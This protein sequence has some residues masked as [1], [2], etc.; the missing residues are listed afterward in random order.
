MDAKNNHPR[1]LWILSLAEFGER[2]G[3]YTMLGIFTLYLLS[4]SIG[5]SYDQANTWYGNFIA[6]VYFTPFIGA[7]LA[8]NLLKY[9]KSITIGGILMGLGYFSLSVA[10]NYF[11]VAGLV[12]IILGN[13]FFKPNISVL[14][15]RLYKDFGYSDD[16]KQKGFNIFYF[17]INVGAFLSN[18]V[19]AYMR[20]HYSWGWAYI[21]A[22]IGMFAAIIWFNASQMAF[23]KELKVVDY[24]DEKKKINL[25]DIFLKFLLPI[26]VFGATGFILPDIFDLDTSKSIFKPSNLAFIT[27][28]IFVGY[29]F[30]KL[31]KNAD[32]LEKEPIKGLIII[33]L[34]ISIFWALFHTSGAVMTN[35][36]A[37]KI[38][39]R[40]VEGTTENVFS[41]FGLT[42]DVTR[43]N[44]PDYFEI[45]DAYTETHSTVTVVNSELFQSINPFFIL[46]L[47]PLIGFFFNFLKKRGKEPKAATKITIGMAITV[48]SAIV[49]MFSSFATNNFSVKAST[50]WIFAYYFVIT[51]GELWLSPV[52][53]NVVSSAAPKRYESLF[54]GGWFIASAYGNKLS[55]VL[56]N[57]WTDFSNKAYF[58]ATTAGMALFA[59]IIAVLLL[60]MLNRTL[61]S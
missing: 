48:F 54:F 46:L 27:S 38:V 59:V 42:K 29:Y 1:G 44:N 9:R 16:M 43:E 20:I 8:D 41:V 55:G 35:I 13:G 6:L 36:Y 19:A 4:N 17:F 30:Y 12:L 32:K 40:H 21:A 2:F 51:V 28:G 39:N 60:P 49:M 3:F 5:F 14:L 25:K 37:K 7:L 61:K 57:M 26:V 34:I 50:W 52:G 11:L 10:N 45:P 53:L 33:F 31:Y 15:G 47:T 56:S 24:I 23:F 22:G 18:F 58:F